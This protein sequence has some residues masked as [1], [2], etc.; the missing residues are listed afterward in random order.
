[1]EKE[2]KK[3]VMNRIAKGIIAF[4]FLVNIGG[5]IILAATLNSMLG[6]CEFNGPY[7]RLDSS[8]LVPDDEVSNISDCLNMSAEGV[9]HC[10]NGH[11]REIFTY[12]MTNDYDYDNFSQVDRYIRKYGGDCHESAMWFTRSAQSLGYNAK[13]VQFTTAFNNDTDPI[14]RYLHTISIIA[15]EDTYCWLDQGELVSCHDFLSSDAAYD[16]FTNRSIFQFTL[17]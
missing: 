16:D 1:M 17:T 13:Y 5:L 15:D 8:L 4:A 7:Q 6:V 11:F 2:K 3:I 9:A 14:I 10:L 12:N